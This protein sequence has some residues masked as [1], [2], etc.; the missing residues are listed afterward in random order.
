MA[1][2]LTSPNAGEIHAFVA[3][4]VNASIGKSVADVARTLAKITLSANVGN[5]LVKRFPGRSVR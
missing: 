5:Q 4:P 3:T 1:T 2:V